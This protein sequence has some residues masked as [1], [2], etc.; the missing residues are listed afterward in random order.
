[1]TRNPIRGIEDLYYCG[2]DYRLCQ[3]HVE[4][5]L[6]AQKITRTA[7]STIGVPV[8]VEIDVAVVVA[9]SQS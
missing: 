6:Q 2:L 9:I 3:I 8:V 5:K 4:I 7:F 1:M